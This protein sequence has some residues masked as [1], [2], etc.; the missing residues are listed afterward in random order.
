MKRIKLDHSPGP[1]NSHQPKILTFSQIFSTTD[2]NRFG[3]FSCT[4]R[5]SQQGSC[6]GLTKVWLLSWQTA[7]SK[8]HVKYQDFSNVTHNFFIH[9]IINRHSNPKKF[10]PQKH[11]GLCMLFIIILFVVVVLS[12]KNKA[13]G[14]LVFN[15]LERHRVQDC[16]WQLLDKNH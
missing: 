8:F 3:W 1:S 2:G 16:I 12:E 5:G 7:P 9:I 13:I 10:L 6:K 15:D 11:S 14:L 4:S